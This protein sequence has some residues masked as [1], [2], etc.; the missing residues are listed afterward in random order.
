MMTKNFS[1]EAEIAWTAAPGHHPLLLY[2]REK[3]EQSTVQAWN[4]IRE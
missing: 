4:D 1:N 3:H 2:R